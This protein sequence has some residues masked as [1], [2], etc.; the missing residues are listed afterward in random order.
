MTRILFITATRIG[1]AIMNMGV[2]DH[3]ITAHPDARITVGCGPL[4]APLFRAIPEVERVI[5]MKKQKGGGHWLKLWRESVGHRWD[6]VVDLRGSLTSW[7][8]WAGQ[9]FV[10]RP[11]PRAGVR[12]RV[13]E[14]AEV[15]RLGAA[16]GTRLWIDA[17]GEARADAELPQGQ[18]V[19]ALSPAASAV[20]KEWAPERFSELALRLTAEDGL[21]PGAAIAIFGGPGDEARAQAVKAGLEARTVIDLTGQLDLVEAAACLKRAALFVGNDSGL[22]HMAAAAGTPTLGLFGPTDERLYAPWGEKARIVR[23]GD[24]FDERERRALADT[25]RES[26]MGALQVDAVERAAAELMAES[27]K[28]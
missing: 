10:K 22:M 9:R 28:A 26:L 5:V 8:L 1:D 20:F 21:L 27:A 25:S 16:P 24:R 4:A 2:L 3:L 7:F 11:N 19:L 17:A 12:H 15:L 13:E 23:A 6:M 14:A 18:T